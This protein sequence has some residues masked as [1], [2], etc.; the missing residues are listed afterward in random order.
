MCTGIIDMLQ[1]WTLQKRLERF[2]K[3]V[4]KCEDG[5]GLSAICPERY[6][7]RFW[8]RVVLDTFEGLGDLPSDL[9]APLDSFKASQ[10]TAGTDE[11]LSV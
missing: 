11:H 10:S 8:Q 9:A 1:K 5:D 2:A 6:A 7:D 3:T 4:F